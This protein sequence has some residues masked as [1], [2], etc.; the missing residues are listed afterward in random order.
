M[1]FLSLF[2]C[3]LLNACYFDKASHGFI[4]YKKKSHSK[5]QK[6]ILFEDRQRGVRKS[7]FPD[8]EIKFYHFRSMNIFFNGNGTNYI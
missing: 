7:H 5:V 3:N 2:F 1:Y 6:A 8:E 4:I